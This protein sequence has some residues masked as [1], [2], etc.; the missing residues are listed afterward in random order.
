VEVSPSQFWTGVGI[1]SL[2]LAAAAVLWLYFY[3]KLFR[4]KAIIIL[5]VAFVAPPGFNIAAKALD[6]NVEVPGPGWTQALVV[7]AAIN[8]LGV[9]E[10]QSRRKERVWVTYDAFAQYVEQIQEGA[11]KESRIKMLRGF[12]KDDELPDEIFKMCQVAELLW[13]SQGEKESGCRE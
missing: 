10:W 5:A 6:V 9:L 13:P 8:W 3:R 4:V 11:S 7:I 2:A 12:G 1:V